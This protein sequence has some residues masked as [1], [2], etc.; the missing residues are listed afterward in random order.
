MSSLLACAGLCD[1]VTAII[2]TQTQLAALCQ[3]RVSCRLAIPLN[4]ICSP[5]AVTGLTSLFVPAH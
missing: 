1:A 3:A 4:A 5:E 2:D